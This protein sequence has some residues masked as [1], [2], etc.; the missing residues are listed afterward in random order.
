MS[1]EHQACIRVVVVVE[2]GREIT[3]GG[4][5]RILGERQVWGEVR[6]TNQQRMTD[7]SRR[8]GEGTK[9]WQGKGRSS[10]VD[11]VAKESESI[12]VLGGPSRMALSVRS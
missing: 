10:R 11:G 2:Y 6:C 7:G 8:G 12:T 1:W 5:S 9:C 3:G 4:S